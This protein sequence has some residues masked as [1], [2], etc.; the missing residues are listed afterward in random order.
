MADTKNEE[1]LERKVHRSMWKEDRFLATERQMDAALGAARH[2]INAIAMRIAPS[3][4]EVKIEKSGENKYFVYA[5]MPGFMP[6]EHIHQDDGRIASSCSRR[7][8]RTLFKRG[9]D[10]PEMW[11]P[12]NFCVQ[13]D[14]WE[15]YR[16]DA[17]L[18]FAQKHGI[19]FKTSELT[20]S[21]TNYVYAEIREIIKRQGDEA[22]MRNFFSEVASAVDKKMQNLKTNIG[23]EVDFGR[24]F[25]H[26]HHWD[27][28]NGTQ[29]LG[30]DIV[31][32]VTCGNDDRLGISSR[33]LDEHY[34]RDLG[35]FSFEAMRGQFSYYWEE[36]L[37]QMVNC[38]AIRNSFP[39]CDM[40]EIKR[41]IYDP[42]DTEG[43]TQRI[44]Q[45]REDSLKKSRFADEDG[46]PIGYNVYEFEKRQSERE[47]RDSTVSV[48]NEQRDEILEAAAGCVRN[49]HEQM[50]YPDADIQIVRTG[51][52]RYMVVAD[53]PAFQN[54][55]DDHYTVYFNTR[56]A[57]SKKLPFSDPYK[58]EAQN[59]LKDMFRAEGAIAFAKKNGIDF[60]ES[61][62]M[63]M[64]SQYIDSEMKMIIR[65]LSKTEM[66]DLKKKSNA[67]DSL[68]NETLLQDYEKFVNEHIARRMQDLHT[69]N[70]FEIDFAHYQKGSYKWGNDISHPFGVELVQ[71][72]SYGENNRFDFPDRDLERNARRCL[73]GW[74]KLAASG[75][76]PENGEQF[77]EMIA[78]SKIAR[79]VFQSCDME[80]MVGESL[81]EESHLAQTY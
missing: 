33:E 62:F 44:M 79:N 22:L 26:L 48:P 14:I 39:S 53:I 35:G 18:E 27:F 5:S 60:H 68:N 9:V 55:S 13:N 61:A 51:D 8:S 77:L 15:G 46:D 76:Y 57:N 80:R 54:M 65:N 63:R 70:G 64:G 38:D 25:E 32:E 72:I 69:R 56:G 74:S 49:L 21:D 73:G 12:Y 41:Q 81:K 3:D 66:D 40:D 10:A 42:D 28:N 58:A 29:P 78:N 47:K 75:E 67:K 50:G 30:I 16:M 45:A 23:F 52:E 34:R 43:I 11:D 17:A 31:Q 6:Y 2:L 20:D 7:E 59:D 19:E 24:H 71:E 36:M 37:D 1:F 4:Y